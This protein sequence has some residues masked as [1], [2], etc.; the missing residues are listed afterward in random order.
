[1]PVSSL[2][3]PEKIVGGRKV[4]PSSFQN[5]VSGGAPLGSSVVS[6]AANNVVGFQRASVRPATP[7]LS[8]IV[9]TIS[10]NILSQVSNQIE[11]VTNISNKNVDAKIQ[12]IRSEITREIQPLYTKQE[13]NITQLQSVVTN[14]TQQA[15]STITKLVEE[16]RKKVS[17]VNDAKPTGI[18]GNFLKVFKG[19]L[20]FIQFFASKKN[21]DNLD[22]N[23]KSLQKIFTDSFEVAKLIRNTI[24][25]IVGQLSNLPKASPSGSPGLN[26]DLKVPGQGL[27]QTAP[28]G[29]GNL[30]RKGGMFA[31]GAGG[32]AAGAGV[33]NALADTGIAPVRQQPG[34]LGGL[35][36]GLGGIVESFTSAV[37]SLIKGS[38][39][40]SGGTSG[41]SAGGAKTG[42]GGAPSTPGGP[43]GQPGGTNAKD[44]KADTAEEKAFIQTVRE[45]EGTAGSQGYN[46]V[47]G[48]AVVPQLTELTLKELYDASKKGGTNRLPQRLGG[49]V[50]PYAKD[51][52]NSSA[53]G[54]L[55]LMPDTLKGLVEG[56]K[57]SW[58]QKFSPETQNAM[59]LALARQG[60]VNVDKIDI[61]QLRKAN[62]IWAGLGPRYGQT[63]RTLQQSMKIYEENLKEAKGQ[64]Q[65]KGQGGPDLPDWKLSPEKREELKNM[66]TKVS[67]P[68]PSQAAPSVNVLPLDFSTQMPRQ[69]SSPSASPSSGPSSPPGSTGP[70]APFLPAG[71]TDNFLILY[72][73][74][75]Y[76]IVDG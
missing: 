31:L 54:A 68:P 39:E 40:K 26:I 51:K 25:K 59:I 2:L 30:M 60:G 12:E 50:I 4:S 75:I 58:D 47:Y 52:Y 19:A 10:S 22:S 29:L 1:M 5:F 76:N 18:L 64:V 28:R 16:Y 38:G 27:K 45:T 41:G 11:S 21:L 56:G 55:Q 3:S 49:G 24:N 62:S 35:V 36:E 44:I 46:T 72:S 34:F 42:P 69:A 15:D 67:Q 66:A 71:N 23:L 73:K 65:A 9:N 37:N 48:G 20:D 53:S 17:E 70:T 43:P 13:N 8:S 14:I 7:D 33:V 61:E 74:I 6:S 57:F 63:K 32:L